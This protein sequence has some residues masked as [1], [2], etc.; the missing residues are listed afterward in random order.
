MTFDETR[1]AYAARAEEYV[2]L[3]G[4]IGAAAEQD[5]ERL[6]KWARGIV[7]RIIDVGCGPGQWTNYLLGQGADIEGIDPV[8]EFVDE[9]RQRY[10]GVLYRVGQAERIEAEDAALGGILAWYSL[11]HAD[12]NR[13]DVALSEFARCTRP[14]GGLAIGFFEGPELV[15]FDHAVTTAYFWPT[16]LL[17]ARVEEAGFMVTYSHARAEPGTRRQGVLFAQRRG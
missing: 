16:E 8:Q 1:G 17:S 11:I 15:S 10:P 14:G 13:I 4:S 12:P 7:G 2:D 6:G 9:A 5:R 3:F